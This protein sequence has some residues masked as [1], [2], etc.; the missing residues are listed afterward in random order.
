MAVG[1]MLAPLVVTATAIEHGTAGWAA[2]AALFLIAGLS[3]LGLVRWHRVHASS[4]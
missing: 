1:T 3:T 4:V 2:L